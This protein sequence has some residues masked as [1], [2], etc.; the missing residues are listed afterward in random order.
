MPAMTIDV[1]S[2]RIELKQNETRGLLEWTVL[3]STVRSSL[4]SL[5]MDHHMVFNGAYVAYHLRIL[6]LSLEIHCL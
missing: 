2:S 3:W 4:I 6:Q 1:T 5:N